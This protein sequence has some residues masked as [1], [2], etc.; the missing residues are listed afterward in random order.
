MLTQ[1]WTASIRLVMF[2]PGNGNIK[3]VRYGNSETS[4]SLA[5]RINQRLSTYIISNLCPV[6]T[7]NCSM[8]LSG[9][10]VH[11][12]RARW[13]GL[14]EDVEKRCDLSTSGHTHLTSYADQSVSFAQW[15]STAEEKQAALASIP[16]LPGRVCVPVPRYIVHV[17]L[18]SCR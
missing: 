14:C 5:L 9:N 6:T 12:H 10:C 8:L 3:N 15:L 4:L 1:C 11:L 7:C 2:A 18:L 13:E 17:C 16:G